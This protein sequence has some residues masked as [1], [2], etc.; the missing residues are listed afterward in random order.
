MDLSIG[1][2]GAGRAMSC[3]NMKIRCNSL[4]ISMICNKKRKKAL[5]PVFS[6]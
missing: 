4:E 3:R 2:R 5:E 1:A 6:S